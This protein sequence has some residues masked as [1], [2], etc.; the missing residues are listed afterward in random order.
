MKILLIFLLTWILCGI[1]SFRM[2]IRTDAL[3]DD[4]KMFDTSDF[5][6]CF[7]FF[8]IGGYITFIL[9]F[10]PCLFTFIKFKFNIH[11]H[12]KGIKQKF[13]RF[14]LGKDIVE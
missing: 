2:I 6:F 5:D 7:W 10:I 13:Y 8:T 11:V 4:E 12:L 3:Y 9:S 1:L 14:I